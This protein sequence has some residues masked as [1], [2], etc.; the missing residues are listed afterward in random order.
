MGFAKGGALECTDIVIGQVSSVFE[1]AVSIATLGIGAA[2]KAPAT[3]SKKLVDMVE[4]IK[5]A[6][7]QV[8]GFKTVVDN[9]ALSLDT[10][11]L[12]SGGMPAGDV[13]PVMLSEWRLRLPRC[14]ENLPVSLE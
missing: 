13:K 12:L 4:A 1:A 3:T 9:V 10:C 7:N 2:A 11:S 14:W 5:K 8:S 6:E